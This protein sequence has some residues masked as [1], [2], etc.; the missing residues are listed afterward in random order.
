MSFV[1]ETTFST[2]TSI[3]WRKD[4]E[5]IRPWA[6]TREY[7]S[8]VERASALTRSMTG[9]EKHCSGG[10]VSQAADACGALQQSPD[11]LRAG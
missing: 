4:N 5:T 1:V 6:G 7:C 10:G 9:C 2:T 11:K 8:G 3:S